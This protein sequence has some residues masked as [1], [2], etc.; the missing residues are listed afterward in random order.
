MSRTDVVRVMGIGLVAALAISL[1]LRL[2]WAKKS[3]TE[4][5]QPDALDP[6][7]YISATVTDEENAA[8]WL[9]AASQALVLTEHQ[10]SFIGDLTA[11]PVKEWTSAQRAELRPLLD[12]A[13]PAMDLLGRAVRFSRT[14]Y[15][16]GVDDLK[17]ADM[18]SHKLPLLNI[19]WLGRFLHVAALDAL[20]HGDKARFLST[21]RPLALLAVSTERETPLI[22]TLVGL[23]CD[24]MFM[25]VVRQAIAR[26]ETDALT[27]DELEQLILTNDL[28]EVWQRTVASEFALAPLRRGQTT[29]LLDRPL[30]VG[31]EAERRAIIA[32]L[33]ESFDHPFGSSPTWLA[34]QHRRIAQATKAHSEV[35]DLLVRAVGRFQHG[36]SARH[37]AHLALGLR[38]EVLQTG[39]YP[40][41]LAPSPS[42]SQPDPF[43]GT[44][45]VLSIKPD[46][47][48]V[49]AMPDGDVV[50]KRF[51]TDVSPPKLHTW[52]LPAR[53]RR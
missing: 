46:G 16:L 39:S 47:S 9:R 14:S 43:Y 40:A 28:R 8:L 1:S 2:T 24:K 32:A 18:N 50:Y 33:G 13:Q 36:L 48:A 52:Q 6:K 26:P 23:A 15:G 45:P 17:A 25:E 22:A 19:I 27:L 29:A 3:A 31:D 34:E 11:T 4:A 49:L 10:R 12:D 35:P 21:V 20:E 5:G 42:A 53:P 7:T 30:A 44:R 41:T 37:L 51:W 38:R